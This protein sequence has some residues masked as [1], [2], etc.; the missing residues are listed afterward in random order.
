MK[1]LRRVARLITILAGFADL[2]G[3]G[4]R[5]GTPPPNQPVPAVSGIVP[6]FVGLGLPRR[7]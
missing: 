3:C 1:S 4:G 7:H 6:S 5:P 2:A